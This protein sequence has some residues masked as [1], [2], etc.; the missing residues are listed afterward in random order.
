MLSEVEN[1]V[2]DLLPAYVLEALTE[3][4]T[5]LVA[6]H[7]AKCSVCQVEAQRL[8]QV[9]DELPLALAQNAPP[10][11]LKANLFKAIHAQQPAAAAIPAGSFWQQL[12]DFV[13]KPI[14]A[15]GVVLILLMLVSN[16]LLIRQV[17]LNQ[18]A[19]NTGMQ[20][21]ALANTANSPGAIGTLV[22][23]PNG[24]YGSLIVDSLASLAPDQQYQVWLIKDSVRTSGGVFSV[25]ADGYA[26]LELSAPLPLAQYDSIGITIEPAGGSP[27]PT[28]A[29]VQGGQIPH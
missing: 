4:E 12:R 6:E 22:M 7:L 1:H 24:K 11:G 26:S 2:T 23:D 17:T 27:G 18:Q 15:M 10:P 14:P 9:A 13:R 29:K 20:G 28:G 19:A 5:I 25:N 21:F 8:Q 16:V 3:D